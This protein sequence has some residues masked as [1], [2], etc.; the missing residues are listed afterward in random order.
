MWNSDTKKGRFGPKKVE[1]GVL[2]AG[3]SGSNP[4]ITI[5]L[6]RG[7]NGANPEMTIEPGEDRSG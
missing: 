5:E 3:Q 7:E 6:V 2:Q 4:E 1:L